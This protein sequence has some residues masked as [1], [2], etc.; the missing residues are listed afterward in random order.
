MRNGKNLLRVT[1]AIGWGGGSGAVPVAMATAGSP[2]RHALSTPDAV[3]DHP[4]DAWDHELLTHTQG[5]QKKS[6]YM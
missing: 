4:T 5:K 3:P 2:G 6:N 1:V